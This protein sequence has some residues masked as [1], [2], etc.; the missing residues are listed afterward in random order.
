VLARQVDRLGSSLVLA[1]NR[2]DL[3]FR[4]PIRFIVRP[5]IEA[6]L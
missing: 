3:L 6:G 4:E 1:Q 5:L 2:D